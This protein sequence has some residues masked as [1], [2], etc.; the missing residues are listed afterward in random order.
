[1]PASNEHNRKRL[2]SGRG[3]AVPSPDVLHSDLSSASV[4]LVW[5]CFL[6]GS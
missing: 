5:R 4:F 1:M 6:L 2:D 3:L